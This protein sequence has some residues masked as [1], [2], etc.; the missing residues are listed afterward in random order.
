MHTLSS[1]EWTLLMLL[2]GG[3]Y[4]YLERIRGRVASGFRLI[5]P[6][7][8]CYRSDD[9][10]LAQMIHDRLADAVGT[11]SV[12][13]AGKSLRSAEDYRIQIEQTI[14]TC[15]S[16]VAV[17]GEGWISRMSGLARPDDAVRQEIGI[18]LAQGV[19]I[20][21]VLCDGQ[22]MP[23]SNAFPKELRHCHFLHAV[24]F[25][26]K[27]FPDASTVNLVEAVCRLSTAPRRRES[28]NT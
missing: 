10:A 19:P 25:N 12:W 5:R 26:Y 14:P 7:F 28:V 24:K 1:L 13:M 20:L 21:P 2:L 8:I 9:L 4:L 27:D 22:E 18:A 11:D 6:V 23:E 16:M 15:S 17:I 3:A